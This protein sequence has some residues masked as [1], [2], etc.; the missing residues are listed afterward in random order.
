MATVA[1]FLSVFVGAGSARAGDVLSRFPPAP[2]V[3]FTLIRNKT[4]VP[5]RFE[6]ARE[7]H[8][9]LDSGMG[10][11]GLLLFKPSLKDSLGSWSSVAAQIPGAGGGP[12]S[13][14]TFADSLAFRVG[15]VRFENQRVIILANDAMASPEIDGVSRRAAHR[16]QEPSAR[17]GTEP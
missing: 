17:A 13:E 16:L 4:V 5:V 12:P 7:L 9:I 3:P 8:I 10:F 15:D 1:G 2:R 6:G 14:A 11:D